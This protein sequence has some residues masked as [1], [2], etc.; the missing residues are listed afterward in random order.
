MY[1]VIPRGRRIPLGDRLDNLSKAIDLVLSLSSQ[2][3]ATFI[4][5]PWLDHMGIV[6]LNGRGL[7][8]VIREWETAIALEIIAINEEL[9]AGRKSR[10]LTRD[11]MI[12]FGSSLNFVREKFE[13]VQTSLPRDRPL[14]QIPI[15]KSGQRFFNPQD[16]EDRQSISDSMLNDYFAPKKSS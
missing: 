8:R 5:K 6:P 12:A 14:P 7:P 13:S 9:N 16:V 15:D 2:K 11:D 1:D 3:E 10:S 4:R